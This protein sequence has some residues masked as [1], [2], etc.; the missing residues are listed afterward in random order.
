MK[1]FILAGLMLVGLCLMEGQVHA[2]V[3]ANPI[4]PC[5]RFPRQSIAINVSSATTTQL[6]PLLA[7]A[8]IYVCSGYLNQVNGTGSLGLEYGT[9]TNCGTGT[10]ELNG[11]ILASTAASGVTTTSL[12]GIDG[13]QFFVPAGN[14]LC[15]IS[16]GTIKQTG[17]IS[18]VQT[19]DISH[20]PGGD[21]CEFLPKLSVPVSVSTGSTTTGLITGI[22]GASTYIC[23][24]NLDSVDGTTDTFALE[25]GTTVST[26]CDT[27]TP[28]LLTGPM[29][30]PAVASVTQV[31]QMGGQGGGTQLV[32][33]AGFAV[34]GLTGTSADVQ[35]GWLTYVQTPSVAAQSTFD[36]CDYYPKSSK[37]FNL[38]S[39]TVAELVA[40]VAGQ[41]T[42][43]CSV[44][45]EDAGRATTANTTTLEYGT[46]VSTACDTGATALTG[47]L[48]GS[49]TAGTT[50][51]L[52]DSSINTT[53]AVPMNKELCV[54]ATQTSNVRGWIA[55]VQR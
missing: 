4:D 17:Y 23:G 41:T 40:P 19:N 26:A 38:S 46:K 12:D 54:V 10:K 31:K 9:G 53:I 55:Y 30:V 13:N 42:Y 14:A 33:P 2:Q 43:V 21:P 37:T 25:Y 28:V 3:N 50:T 22:A 34:C 47:P 15:A 39:T 1:R 49:L 52:N 8:S 45:W 35:G 18:Y 36:P 48:T 5:A 20:S 11:P 24:L 27:G 7:G 32:A 44:N 6:V 51:Q 16:T 29:A